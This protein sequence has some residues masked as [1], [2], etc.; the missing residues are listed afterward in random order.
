MAP[1]FSPKNSVERAMIQVNAR[2]LPNHLY[3]RR[4]SLCQ[5]AL[6]KGVMCPCQVKKASR[7]RLFLDLFEAQA[8]QTHHLVPQTPYLHGFYTH[9]RFSSKKRK[10]LCWL[11]LADC[12]ASLLRKV[13]SF[14]EQASSSQFVCSNCCS[15]VA[16]TEEA[17]CERIMDKLLDS[18]ALA[19]R[20]HR[21]Q[22]TV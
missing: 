20:N 22:R 15:N 10:M 5:E 4:N 9:S 2:K 17:L 3:E 19:S 13:L 7:A 12:F 1:C 8:W 6:S 16:V 11:W 18:H 14:H 21:R